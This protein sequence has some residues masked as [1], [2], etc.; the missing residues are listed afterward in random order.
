LEG[1]KI[2]ESENKEGSLKE[3]VA[4]E[5]Y[6]Q[7]IIKSQEESGMTRVDYCRSHQV[8]YNRLGYWY[9]KLQ[10]NQENI[11]V[12]ITL[13]K[14]LSPNIQKGTNKPLSI[15]ELKNGN[16]LHIYDKEI[17]LMILNRLA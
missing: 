15:L 10:R 11:F 8:N 5:S 17:L 16:F 13:K 3:Q 14:E 2:V 12:P 7:E 1:A 6:W 9:R 4:N